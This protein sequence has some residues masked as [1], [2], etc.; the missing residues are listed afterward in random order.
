MSLRQRL[1]SQQAFVIKH[2]H[3]KVGSLLQP[4]CDTTLACVIVITTIIMA[5]TLR[6]DIVS[7][8]PE[9]TADHR[10]TLS[11]VISVSSSPPSFANAGAIP[12]SALPH[13]ISFAP[14]LTPHSSLA[15]FPASFA[16][17]AA[18]GHLALASALAG[19]LGL[20]YPPPP[21]QTTATNG[22]G[23]MLSVRS[24]P[25]ASKSDR[26][27]PTTP[28]SATYKNH[29]EL[30]ERPH[31]DLDNAN[32]FSFTSQPPLPLPPQQTLSDASSSETGSTQSPFGGRT[33]TARTVAASNN[34][35]S[36]VSGDVF[37]NGISNRDR[38]LSDEFDAYST[39]GG[40]GGVASSADRDRKQREFIPDSK[41]D[42]KYWERRRKNNE[43]AKR[44]R[45]KRRQNDVL[46]EHRISLLNAQNNKLRQELVELK[47]RFGLPLNKSDTAR[48][49]VG[50]DME[51]IGYQNGTSNGEE[52]M[53][54]KSDSY[55]QVNDS[56][57]Q[58]FCDGA[59]DGLEQD[60]PGMK[61]AKSESDNSPCPP[62]LYEHKADDETMIDCSSEPN[63]P[64]IVS[65]P[66]CIPSEPTVPAPLQLPPT[67]PPLD[68]A[69]LVT[70]KRILSSLAVVGRSNNGSFD[71]LSALSPI[72]SSAL[73]PQTSLDPLIS[74]ISPNPLIVDSST[75]AAAAWI[76]QQTAS[77]TGAIAPPLNGDGGARSNGAPN[78]NIVD[79]TAF[80]PGAPLPPTAPP[81]P[82][83]LPTARLPPSTVSEEL[84]ESPL[85][86]S[87][88]VAIDTAPIHGKFAVSCVCRRFLITQEL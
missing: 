22:G 57:V 10:A 84:V 23:A 39:N 31:S 88:C 27:N 9:R 36:G 47:V 79:P 11:D 12:T 64:S 63:H 85:D 8:T 20:P 78:T 62:M 13:A 46:M 37:S 34:L 75:A 82:P 6:S 28:H 73:P 25:P 19:M 43:A 77:N 7:A 86:L 72:D 55:N 29:T 1:T 50:S 45:E 21:P 5:A 44:S 35:V 49:E 48:A 59:P 24:N 26:N 81:P 53:L 80:V 52:H 2:S 71:P 54:S 17:D 56:P 70:L 41:K 65:T 32:I 51:S 3:D 66:T 38:R 76:F 33:P 40:V 83:A 68:N 15:Q 14:N 87:L 58:S 30:V 67:F 16:P 69:D 18:G 4:D 60:E 74:P 61:I 42:D